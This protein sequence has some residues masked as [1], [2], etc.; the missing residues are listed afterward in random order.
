[1]KQENNKKLKIAIQMDDIKT[2]N[3]DTDS[4]YVIALEAQS[5]SHELYYYNPQNLFLENGKVKA[6]VTALTLSKQKDNYYKLGEKQTVSLN[7][8]DIILM[9][10]DPPYDMN[11]LTYTYFLEMISNDCLVL[12]NPTE[13]RNCPEKIFSC[14]FADLMPK[15]LISSDFDAVSSFFDDLG[16]IILKPLYAHGGCD[17]FLAQNKEELKDVFEKLTNKYQQPIIAQEYIAN[18]SKGDKRII[19][20][21]GEIAGAI[22]RLPQDGGILSNM[23]Q[24]GVAEKTELTKR[25]IHICN[26]ISPELKKR[27]L[28]L[29]GIDVIDGYLTEINVTSPTGIQAIN[30]LYNTSLE[31]VFWDKLKV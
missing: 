6:N 30:K 25:E 31:K 7:M 11:Y 29:V 16:K 15:T 20:I 22:N 10:Q 9:R 8:M 14:M 1:M 17:V 18:V 5:R 26:T 21:D 23:A 27:G 28:F 4:T 12:N 19:L 24:G 2:I 13:V 3:L